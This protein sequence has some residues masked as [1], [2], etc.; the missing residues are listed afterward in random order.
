LTG[1]FPTFCVVFFAIF[2]L[3]SKLMNVETCCRVCSI[4]SV[5][6]RRCRRCAYCD[7]SEPC[8]WSLGKHFRLK[9]PGSEPK[10]REV[11]DP[12]K[13]ARVEEMVEE[14]VIQLTLT[15]GEADSSTWKPPGAAAQRGMRKRP[16]GMA[17]HTAQPA[18]P[19]IIHPVIDNSPIPL[20]SPASS[21][22]YDT[23]PR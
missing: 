17:D 9:H 10:T 4:F 23:P 15:P 18:P 6:I 16:A 19:Q 20:L 12:E 2:S 7:Y 3:Y 13:D 14:C 8:Q 5:S 11:R 22:A 1:I 21:A